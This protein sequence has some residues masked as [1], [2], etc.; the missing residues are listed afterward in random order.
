MRWTAL[1]LGLCLL[2][3][4]GVQA[5][6]EIHDGQACYGLSGP[7]RDPAVYYPPSDALMYRYRLTGLAGKGG[8]VDFVVALKLVDTQGQVVLQGTD[9]TK[10]R[11][12][13]G[14][15]CYWG[16]TQLPMTTALPPGEYTV[17]VTATDNVSHERASFRRKVRLAS[18]GPAIAQ[19]R[20]TQDPQS[21]IPAGTTCT[22]GQ[23]VYV[24]V[25]VVGL[26]ASPG[27]VELDQDI[28]VIDS[29]SKEVIWSEQRQLAEEAPPHANPKAT[30]MMAI[31]GLTRAGDFTLRVRATDGNTHKTATYEV[32]LH[33]LAPH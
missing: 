4:G 7:A 9:P 13:L 14:A 2:T 32:P 3:A 6:L 21:T 12:A 31:N 18:G 27:K 24:K 30:I 5:K 16:F 22:V 26:D 11:P 28:A 23:G 25:L 20:V 17:V 19:V 10:V 15:A 33:V 29:T 1:C 8:Q